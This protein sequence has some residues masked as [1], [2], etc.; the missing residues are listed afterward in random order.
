MMDNV[1]IEN[2]ISK[3][4]QDIIK[5]LM[6]FEIKNNLNNNVPKYQSD[7]YMHAKY[8]KNVI[9]KKILSLVE[10]ESKKTYNKKFKID[11][12]WFNICKE[13]SKFDFHTHPDAHTSCVIYVDGCEDYGTLIKNDNKIAM[14]DSK[15]C[16]MHFFDSKI[17]HSIPQWKD[18]DRYTIAFDLIEDKKI[19]ND[20]VKI[21]EK[22]GYIY[23]PELL[24]EEN[25]HELCI[26]LRKY[27]EMGMTTNDIQ[28]PGSESIHGS[29]TFDSLL[30]QLKPYF[31]EACGKKLHPTYSYARLYSPGEVLKVHKDRP[32]C[33]ISAT[34]T[35]G[36]EGDNW[37]IWMGDYSE[38]ETNFSRFDE[39]GNE[40]YI[41]NEKNISMNT[42]DAVLY[43]GMEKA[44]WRDEYKTGIWQ[45]QVF[46]HYVDADGDYADQIYDGRRNLTHH[47]PQ[48]HIDS[49]YVSL[50]NHFS[51]EACRRIIEASEKVNGVEGLVGTGC[52]ILNKEVRDV[53]RTNM[54]IDHG[55]GATLTGIGLN[56]NNN[57]WKYKITCS[58][59]CDYLKYDENGHYTAHID[60][61]LDEVREECRKLTVLLF[62]NDDFE[63][64][65]LFLQ[66]SD[67]KIYPPQKP[68]DIVIFPSFVLH[69]VEP[70]TSGIRR[71][72]VTWLVGPSFK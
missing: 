37:T 3:E 26:E 48:K 10:L 49:F 28:C 17:P 25:C 35:I 31:E 24:D 45:A 66:T 43:K 58:N 36:F 67:K 4:E 54:S 62:L 7:N 22:D 11:K 9:F 50:Q 42:G 15:N 13:D 55:V 63:G 1:L 18:E 27:I 16:S 29:S 56:V 8:S 51:L 2:I 68:G 69:G 47:L 53:F 52:G 65:R 19:M 30:E 59:Q 71:S 12:C 32:A 34:I 21:F 60:T 64:G 23:I 5:K 61:F 46:L 44:H 6:D 20:Y 40:I 33:E 14:L 72:I 38:E 41:T 70:V 39:Q 57:K